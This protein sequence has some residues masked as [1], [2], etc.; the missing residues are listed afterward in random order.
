MG[1][2]HYHVPSR[3]A[4][5]IAEGPS[6][7]GRGEL[8]D[9]RANGYGFLHAGEIDSHNDCWIMELADAGRN[10]TNG[11]T[12][13][14]GY[15][16]SRLHA[17]AFDAPYHSGGGLH[18]QRLIQANMFRDYMARLG[19]RN[20][21]FRESAVLCHADLLVCL[22]AVELTL[23]TGRT[24][25]TREVALDRDPVAH[26]AL[27]HAGPYLLDDSG[28]FVAGHERVPRESWRHS[29]VEDLQISAA[30]PAVC[31]AND[32]L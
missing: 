29:P 23:P 9:T 13:D 20:D 12:T 10:Q 26:T 24:S 3:T 19:R 28:P 2:I 11:S 7:C 6:V 30:Q 5:T 17:R 4:A 27:R 31:G 21:K 18:H 1:T 16:R 15:G 25:A 8:C 22:T 14:N 32:D